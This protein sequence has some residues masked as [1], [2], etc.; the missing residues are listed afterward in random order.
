MCTMQTD[1]EIIDSFTLERGLCERSKKLYLTVINHYCRIQDMSIAQLLDEAEREEDE[2]IR[3]KRR[4]L[5]KRLLKFREYLVENFSARTVTQY[6]SRI[7]TFYYHFEIEVPR[8]PKLN[9]KR[10][11]QYEP[12]YYQDLPDKDIIREAINLSSPK[13]RAIILFECSSGCG[14]RET[15]NLTVGDFLEATKE[16]YDNSI[17]D[18]NQIIFELKRRDDVVPTFRLARQKTNKYYFTFC[19][20]EAVEAICNWLLVRTDNYGLD[21]PLFNL[22]ESTYIEYFE[23]INNT[24]NLGKV[25]A[26]N[27]FRG[28]MLRKFHAT[29]LYQGKNKLSLDEVDALQGRTQGGS[30]ESYF[31]TDMDKLKERYIKA[32]PNVTIMDTIKRVIVDDEESVKLIKEYEKD[33]AESYIEIT[34]LKNKNKEVVNYAKAFNQSLNELGL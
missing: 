17:S 11:K 7:K 10:L 27:R 1:M 29:Q 6:M 26:W 21:D 9:K 12:I 20:P 18:I 30:R 2:G 25:G 3:L 16:Y 13:F 33:L 5:K 22:S 8:L 31:M 24:L 19:S 4:T 14:R 15:L 32:L 23:K 34:E 28:H